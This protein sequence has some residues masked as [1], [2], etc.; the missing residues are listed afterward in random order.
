MEST[1][2]RMA[3]KGDKGDIIL[4]EKLN[5]SLIGNILYNKHRTFQLKFSAV[6]IQE[7]RQDVLPVQVIQQIMLVAS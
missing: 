5:L 4:S 6:S 3:K 2:F 1:G 7:T